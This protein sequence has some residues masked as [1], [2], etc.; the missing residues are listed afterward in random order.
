[1]QRTTS[2]L[3]LPA[4]ASPVETKCVKR[5]LRVSASEPIGFMLPKRSQHDHH[6]IHHQQS[7]DAYD[8]WAAEIGRALPTSMP[9]FLPLIQNLSSAC[10]RGPSVV[11]AS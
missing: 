3:V 8:E 4:I 9:Y 10:P 1:M 11:L 2:D 7:D 6:Y 5:T